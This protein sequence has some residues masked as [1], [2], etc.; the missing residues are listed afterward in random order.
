MHNSQNIRVLVATSSFAA[1]DPTPLEMLKDAG[2]E[3][4]DNPFKRKLTKPE[5][6]S[7]LENGIK[8]TI[9]GLETLDREVMEKTGLKVISRCGSGMSNVDQNAAKEFG[10]KAKRLLLLQWELK[11][12]KNLLQ[13]HMDTLLQMMWRQI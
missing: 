11:E 13:E 5:L 4:I 6:L 8:G 10:I 2:V 12:R 3:V 9:A 7:L 1:L